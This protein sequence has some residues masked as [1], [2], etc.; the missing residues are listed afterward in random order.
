MGCLRIMN[1]KGD[2]ERVRYVFGGSVLSRGKVGV[3]KEIVGWVLCL[4]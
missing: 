4:E 2:G 1:F 3:N